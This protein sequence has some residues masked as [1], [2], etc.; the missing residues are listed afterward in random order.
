MKSIMLLLSVWLLLCGIAFADQ[1]WPQAVDLYSARNIEFAGIAMPTSTGNYLISWKDTAEPQLKQQFRLIDISGS[2]LWQ[3]SFPLVIN[4]ET[5]ELRWMLETGGDYLLL[6]SRGTGFLHGFRLNLSGG[7]V[8]P[9]TGIQLTHA[10]LIKPQSPSKLLSDGNG[11]FIHLWA[12]AFDGIDNPSNYY[13]QHMDSQGQTAIVNGATSNEFILISD[14]ALTGVPDLFLLSDGGMICAYR[15]SNLIKIRRMAPNHSFTWTQEINAGEPVWPSLIDTRDGC[16]N[17]IWHTAGSISAMRYD[18]NFVAQW[19]QPIQL[20]GTLQ[21][22]TAQKRISTRCADGKTLT[23]WQN[24]S[25]LMMQRF[26]NSGTQECDSNGS[27]V[28]E[29]VPLTAR[30]EL[31][32]DAGGG[33]F[34]RISDSVSG[35][36][37]GQ[38]ISSANQI[39]PQA[40]TLAQSMPD[41]LISAGVSSTLFPS[42]MRCY[43]QYNSPGIS[44]IQTQGMTANGD[45]ILPNQAMEIVSGTCGRAFSPLAV[46]HSGKVLCAWLDDPGFATNPSSL[47]QINYQMV[48]QDGSTV[49]PVPRS[50]IAA[51]CLRPI[52]DLKAIKTNF[53]SVLICWLEDTS[54]QV[55]KA[56]LIDAE[57]N[58]VWEPG[59]RT[60]CTAEIQGFFSGGYIRLTAA[61]GAVYVIWAQCLDR[62]TTSIRAQKI[63]YNQILWQDGGKAL[64]SNNGT[65]LKLIAADQDYII[66]G[67]T[68]STHNIFSGVW[69]SRFTTDGNLLKGFADNI[70]G[71]DLAG[72]TCRAGSDMLFVAYSNTEW[73]YEWYNYYPRGQAFSA[74]GERL[75]GD[76]GISGFWGSNMFTQGNNL[77]LTRSNNYQTTLHGFNSDGQV[78]FGMPLPSNPPGGAYINALQIDTSGDNRMVG[79]AQHTPVFGGTGLYYFCF[80]ASGWNSLDSDYMLASGAPLRNPSLCRLNNDVYAIWGTSPTFSDSYI[81][82]IRLQRI[83]AHP[84]DNDDPLAPPPVLPE[85]GLA[86]PNPFASKVSFSAT[87]P[88][89]GLSEIGIYN[90]R[91]Q[92]VRQIYSGTLEQGMNSLEWDGKDDAGRIAANGIYICKALLNGTS[93]SIRVVKLR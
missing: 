5:A 20:C 68:T 9:E 14:A 46:A 48:N 64:Y 11:G 75:W 50:L 39:L 33:C 25:Q 67:Y 86:H 35:Q 70:L 28:M 54:P 19:L 21:G 38:Y 16:F 43:Y 13:L 60:I 7:N 49:F 76:G 44:E 41:E 36:I 17:L 32:P 92:L 40:V 26:D 90:L 29:Q 52:I 61:H 58:Q 82:S 91:G 55:L 45:I 87:L 71:Y 62:L 30:F 2:T 56:Q 6:F 15:E 10:N 88:Q 65:G 72:I 31:M 81:R 63:A 93:H 84:V 83:S 4:G 24:G 12:W 8:W 89:R 79:I 27:L 69:V 57:G 53:G 59:G 22:L 77:F 85:L 37:W 34:V 1:V 18:Y 73:Q 66:H 3:R 78:L 74:I 80:D 23:L 51:D 42:G 47:R